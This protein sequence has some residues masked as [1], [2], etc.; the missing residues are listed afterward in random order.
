[1]EQCKVGTTNE[2]VDKGAEQWM[3]ECRGNFGCKGEVVE[4]VPRF[5]LRG[6]GSL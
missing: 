6:V 1:M 5:N 2:G 4:Q 3:K